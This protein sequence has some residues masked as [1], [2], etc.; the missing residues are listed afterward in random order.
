LTPAQNLFKFPP[1][2]KHMKAKLLED[3]S[4]LIKGQIYT[5]E[6]YGGQ[7]YDVVF[8]KGKI[9]VYKWRFEVVQPSPIEEKTAEIKETEARL[10]VLKKELAELTEPKVGQKWLNTNSNSKYILAS[11][12]SNKF[13]LVCYEGADLG[14]IYHLANSTVGAFYNNERYFTL[15]PE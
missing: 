14:V 3:Y 7:F 12:T 13:A 1:T 11:T 6:D 5:V 10:A 2:Q 9:G 15:L 8:P 4:D